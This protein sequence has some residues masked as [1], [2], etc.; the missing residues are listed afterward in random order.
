[1]EAAFRAISHVVCFYV[2]FA[3][4]SGHV[5]CNQGYPLWANSGD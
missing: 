5:Q 1:M 2:R 4:E 3:S